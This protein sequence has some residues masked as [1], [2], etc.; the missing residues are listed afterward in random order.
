MLNKGIRRT[1][2]VLSIVAVTFVGAG[3]LL[4]QNDDRDKLYKK[5]DIF[6]EVMNRIRS[7]YVESVQPDMIFDGA[8][9]GMARVLDSESSYLTAEEYKHYLEQDRLRSARSGISVIKHPGNGYAMVVSLQ[10]DSP[11]SNSGLQKGDFIRAVDSI[12]TRELPLI[13]IDLLL[14]G[15]VGSVA[16]MS[17]LRANVQGLLTFE[18]PRVE[19]AAD[20]VSTSDFTEAGYVRLPSFDETSVRA[21]SAACEKFALDGKTAVIVD[22]RGNAIGTAEDAAKAAELFIDGGAMFSL[23]GREKSVEVVADPERVPLDLFV[24]V[25]ESSVR[26]AEAFALAIKTREAGTLVG[27]PTLGIGSRQKDIILEDGAFL[28]ISYA[29]VVA[30]DGAELQGKGVEPDIAV[31]RT[32]EDGDNDVILQTALDRAKELAKQAA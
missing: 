9:K 31:D 4:G 12:S 30:P 26:G 1:L 10:P 3:M 7:D 18:I 28:R 25:D 32:A 27:R 6:V 21:L 8:L 23:K 2:L 22:I 17:V 11:A 29:I 20:T 14:R 24:L 13:M 5:F 15:E 19:L 16:R